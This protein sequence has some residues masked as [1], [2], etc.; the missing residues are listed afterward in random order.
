M[1][2][3]E[4][5]RA[6]V[7]TASYNVA[8]ATSEASSSW[9]C[10]RW[11]KW[12][13]HAP[14]DRTANTRNGQSLERRRVIASRARARCLCCASHA[15]LFIA[16]NS[17][18]NKRLLPRCR[19]ARLFGRQIDEC[20]FEAARFGS[21]LSCVRVCVRATQTVA[22]GAASCRHCA[23]CRWRSYI[24]IKVSALVRSGASRHTSK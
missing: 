24:M 17:S 2:S 5:V 6:C 16:R 7:C 13:L 20:A 21:S 10:C 14:N 1:R 12:R 23:G 18:R 22:A 4:R 8:G 19:V 9:C 3:L 11:A 15:D